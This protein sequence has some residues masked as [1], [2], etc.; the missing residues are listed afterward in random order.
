MF[1]FA[2]GRFVCKT[3]N[4]SLVVEKPVVFTEKGGGQLYRSLHLPNYDE[5]KFVK[6]KKVK[7]SNQLDLTEIADN[8]K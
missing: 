8:L 3:R 7:N 5:I 2:S 4:E 6:V 1:G